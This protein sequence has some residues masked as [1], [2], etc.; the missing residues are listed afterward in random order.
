M[1]QFHSVSCFMPHSSEVE[2]IFIDDSRKKG[3]QTITY[4][5]FMKGKVS[6][7]SHRHRQVAECE[8]IVCNKIFALALLAI[9]LAVVSSPQ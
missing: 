8:G 1:L 3:E 5:Y 6:F 9:R 2:E 7:S 4:E